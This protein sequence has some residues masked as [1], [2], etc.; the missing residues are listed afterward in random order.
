M[1]KGSNFFYVE[2]CGMSS[3]ASSV[4]GWTYHEDKRGES[5][6]VSSAGQTVV[7]G[8]EDEGDVQFLIMST[9]CPSQPVTDPG[10]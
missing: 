7:N 3:Q 1:P 8:K 6:P 9:R 10:L 4:Q 5:A 2:I